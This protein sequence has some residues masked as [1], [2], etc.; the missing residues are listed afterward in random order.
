MADVI[1]SGAAPRLEQLIL[2]GNQI[3][4]EGCKALAGALSEGAAPRLK[5]LDLGGNQIADQGLII[6]AIAIKG[7]RSPSL[8]VRACAL[9]LLSTYNSFTCEPYL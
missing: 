1:K 9:G 7:G 6:L 2:G 4:D 5:A 8:K 3:G